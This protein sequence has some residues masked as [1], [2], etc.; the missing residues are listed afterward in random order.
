MLT[1]HVVCAVILLLISVTTITTAAKYKTKNPSS[2]P[3]KDSLTPEQT[4][5][6]LHRVDNNLNEIKDDISA[7]IAYVLKGDGRHETYNR[8]AYFT[9]TFGPRLCGTAQYDNA[10]NWLIEQLQNDGLENVHGENA[11]VPLWS[12]GEEE[13]YLISPRYHK[14]NILGLGGSVGTPNTT[15]EAI[16]VGSFDELKSLAAAGKTQGKIIVFNQQCDWQANPDSCYGQTAGYR[17][18]GANEAARAGGVAALVRTLTGQSISS[19]HTGMMA[20]DSDVTQIPTACIT[21]EDADM[22]QRMQDRGQ[23]LVISMMMQASGSS[24]GN[25]PSNNVI[26]EITGS[27]YPNEVVLVSGHVDSWDVGQ[28]AM[29][30]GGGAFISWEV[31]RILKQL[32]LRPKRTIRFVGWSCEEFGGVG[33]DQYYADHK[34]N[35]TNMD[36]VMESDMGVFRAQGSIHWQ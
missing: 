4:S 8:L 5:A 24:L 1:R 2:Y 3:V 13:A 36:L 9:D 12:R 23:K 11:M 14:M 18:D 31:L 26:A 27:T 15:A 29:D 6:L 16:V 28:G 34:A 22:F 21:V 32:N 25:S 17:V 7:I 30:D 33:A 10:A 35:A 19:P 20:Y